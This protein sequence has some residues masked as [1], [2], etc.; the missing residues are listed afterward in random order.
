MHYTLYLIL[1]LTGI[2]GG[3]LGGLIGIGGGIIFVLILPQ[4]L[5][6]E[7]VM[8]NEIAQFS[9]ANSLFAILFSSIAS[10]ISLIKNKNIFPKEVLIIGL[11]S[12]ITAFIVLKGFVNTPAFDKTT[13]NFIVIGLMCFMLVRTLLSTKNIATQLTPKVSNAKL[14]SLGLLSGAIAPLSGL[15]GGIIIIPILNGVMKLE[16]RTANSISLGVIGITSLFTT[17]I[18]LNEHPQ[19]HLENGQIGYISLPIALLLS[20]GV[21]VGSP[22]GI[23]LGKRL[24][25]KTINYIFAAFIA[26]SICK[27]LFELL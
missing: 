4:A 26:L 5:A 11:V 23:K 9:V 27:K 1:F 14:A 19:S 22:Y 16:V 6:I 10:N 7:G 12:V 18:N 17:I 24:Q 3:F 2:L 8:P 21:F 15:G 25:A 13:F 20:V